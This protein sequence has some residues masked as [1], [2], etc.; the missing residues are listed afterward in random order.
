M[1]RT[2]YR[3]WCALLILGITASF[4]VGALVAWAKRM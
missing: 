1:T 3:A 2:V 4:G